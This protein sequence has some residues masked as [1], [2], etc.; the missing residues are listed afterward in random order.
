MVVIDHKKTYFLSIPSS[1]NGMWP[2]S[3]IAGRI[4]LPP[5][6]QDDRYKHLIGR[7]VLVPIQ[8]GTLGDC[9][10]LRLLGMSWGVKTTCLEAPGVSLGGSGVSIGGVGS[11]R[12][13]YFCSPICKWDSSIHVHSGKFQP[14]MLVYHVYQRVGDTWILIRQCRYNLQIFTDMN[15]PTLRIR[16]SPQN[17]RHF[18]DLN[19]PAIQVKPSSIGGLKTIDHWSWTP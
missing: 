13:G 16:F 12:A 15:G 14:A 5:S 10:T 7:D 19:T 3:F 4:L 8:G 1:P 6:C 2:G 11:L 9:N 18:E 17:W